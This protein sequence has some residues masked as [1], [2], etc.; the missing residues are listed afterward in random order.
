ML[1]DIDKR[2]GVNATT[3]SDAAGVR[4]EV[5]RQG[6]FPVQRG[7]L[8]G[9]VFLVA[10]A[11]GWYGFR[12]FS[13]PA[14]PVP[15]TASA[16]VPASTP[17]MPVPA[18]VESAS[19]VSAVPAPVVAPAAKPVA[20]SAPAVAAVVP[21]VPVL[22]DA[23]VV[24]KQEAVRESAKPVVQPNK[25]KAEVAEV[26]VL[27]TP[28]L[29]V[30]QAA[31]KETPAMVAGTVT[32]QLSAEQRADN[33]YREAIALVRQGRGADAQKLLQQILVDS[34][35]HQDARLLSARVL[36]D[37]GKLSQA[38]SLLAEG[39]SLKPQAFQLYSALAH[40][41]LMGKEVDAA[42]ATLERG[43]PA[44]GENAEYQALLAAV[45]QQQ[46]RHNEAVQHYVVALRQL[47]DASNWLVGLGVSLQALNNN[48][49]AA[50]AYQ[51]ALDLG[52]PA[53]LSQFAR[54]KL[55]QL[56]R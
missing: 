31:K 53:S 55:N 49:G 2:Q 54:D 39:V 9:G 52:L 28:D 32:R 7:L 25:T 38:K 29:V 20:E 47:P 12:Q 17:V 24:S 33:A 5:P 50:E 18:P 46:A 26:A 45:L 19:A 21:A 36:T 35:A 51:R 1:K 14:S 23:P 3:F 22:R 16:P 44:A 15:T 40:A 27:P 11:A 37:E 42:A 4:L 30:K 10:V 8:W 34:P 48:D 43:L 56:K 41:Q 6:G 13:A